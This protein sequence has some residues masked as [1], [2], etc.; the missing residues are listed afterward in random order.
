MTQYLPGKTCRPAEFAL[1]AEM[2]M[3]TE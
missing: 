2:G 1:L 3:I